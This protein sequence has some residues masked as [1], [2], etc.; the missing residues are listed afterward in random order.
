[1]SKRT[2]CG[3]VLLAGLLGLGPGSAQTLTNQSVSG[4]FFFRQVSLGT[5]GSGAFTDPRSILGTITFD[6]SGHFS[7]T[8]QQVTGSGAPTS[9]IGS[10]T[11]SVD[12]AGNVVMDSP[13]RSGDR[14][15]AHFGPEALIGSSTESSDNTFDLLVAIPA[16]TGTGIRMRIS[17][18]TSRRSAHNITK[19]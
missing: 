1:M 14:E 19:P 7:F 17:L 10:G 5:D 6:G 13:L 2:G 12:S 16:P 4:K 8:G 11:Y 15:N 3:W 18:R 9:Q